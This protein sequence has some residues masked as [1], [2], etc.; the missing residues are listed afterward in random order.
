MMPLTHDEILLILDALSAKY[1]IGYS[2]V[3]AVGQLQAKL[4]IMLEMAA[5]AAQKKS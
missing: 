3:K 1:G 4:S 5:T 2:D